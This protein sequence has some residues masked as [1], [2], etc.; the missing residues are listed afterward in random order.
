MNGKK[1]IIKLN[2]T[3]IAGTVVNKIKTDCDKV[4]KSS[5]TQGKWKDY[6]AGRCGWLVDTD[7]LVL[8]QAGVTVALNVGTKY[9]LTVCDNTTTGT[10]RLTGTAMMT[11]CDIQISVGHIVKGIFRF[12][13]C[14]ELSEPAQ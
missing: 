10:V 9:T 4:E 14:G 5:P 1:I 13:G 3:A 6:D 2:G 12:L 8:S 11:D 7:F